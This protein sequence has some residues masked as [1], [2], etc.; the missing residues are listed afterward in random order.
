MPLHLFGAI[1][2]GVQVE[3]WFHHKLIAHRL[4]SEW[5]TW[6]GASSLVIHALEIG[7]EAGKVLCP[8]HWETDLALIDEDQ[9]TQL[10]PLPSARRSG[11][12]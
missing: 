6:D 9:Q 3:R 2:G 8:K 12:R 10:R 11:S 4:H 7:F 5:F 1:Q